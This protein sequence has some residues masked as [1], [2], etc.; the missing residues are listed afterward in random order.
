[1]RL[2]QLMEIMYANDE[3]SIWL[4][5]AA[6]LILSVSS[7][8]SDFDRKIFEDPLQECQFAPMYLNMSNS[9]GI[10]RS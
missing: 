1:M 10:N 5:N 7:R 9:I 6:Y 2:Q 8:S 4:T 3:E